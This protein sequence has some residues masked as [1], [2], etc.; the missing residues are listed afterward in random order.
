M[1]NTDTGDPRL[2]FQSVEPSVAT[3]SAMLEKLTRDIECQGWFQ[4]KT[5]TSENKDWDDIDLETFK[6]NLDFVDRLYYLHTNGLDN[7]C[8]IC[9]MVYNMKPVFVEFSARWCFFARVMVNR[10]QMEFRDFLDYCTRGYMVV[11]RNPNTFFRVLLTD[12]D[13]NRR[14][15]IFY[16]LR[17]DGYIIDTKDTSFKHLPYVEKYGVL[18]KKLK[19]KMDEFLRIQECKDF[20]DTLTL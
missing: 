20:Y 1:I 13:D 6:L 18:P 14:D 4:K 17:S 7:F 3:K 9:R 11:T 5:F 2:D 12:L 15:A 16:S 8:I 19:D 10:I